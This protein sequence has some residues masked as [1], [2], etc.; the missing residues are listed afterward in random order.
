MAARKMYYPKN[1]R[2]SPPLNIFAGDTN[3]YSKKVSAN[4]RI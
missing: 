1:V 3:K 4:D 2:S